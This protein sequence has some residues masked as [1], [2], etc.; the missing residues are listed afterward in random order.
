LLPGTIIFMLLGIVLVIGSLLWSLS[1]IWPVPVPDGNGPGITSFTV[2]AASLW[3][4]LYQVLGAFGIALAGLWLVWRFL[5]KTPV[6]GHLVHS[7]AGAMP[8]RVVT[9]GSEIPGQASLPDVGAKGVVSNPL[10][11]LGEVLINGVRYQ[12][13]V[14]VGSLDRGTPIVVTGYRDF[15][16]LVEQARED[17]A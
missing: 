11:P 7:S 4:A 17:S 16:L 14:A 9:G 8:D 15:S 12:A 5:P 13:S 10:H 1:D 2:D 6:Y 3:S